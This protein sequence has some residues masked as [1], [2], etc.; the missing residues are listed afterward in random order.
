LK[1]EV[2][3]DLY[4]PIMLPTVGATLAVALFIAVALCGVFGMAALIWTTVSLRATARVAPTEI[5]TVVFV[6]Y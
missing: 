3:N 6:P 1:I 4:V 2:T 5:N